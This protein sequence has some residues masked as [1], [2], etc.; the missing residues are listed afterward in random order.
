MTYEE[1][2]K[3]LLNHL[4]R[5]C[6][7]GITP[8]LTHQL[9][10]NGVKKTGITFRFPDTISSPII[11]LEDSFELYQHNGD[12]DEIADHILRLYRTIPKLDISEHFLADFSNIKGTITMKLINTEKNLTL[13]DTVPHI[14]FEDLS[15]VFYCI[16]EITDN[17]TGTVLIDNEKAALWD[18]DTRALHQYALKNY[19]DL[20]SA[21]FMTMS[22]QI[23]AIFSS[24][25]ENLALEGKS[26][27]EMP[28]DGFDD[29]MYVLSN[30]YKHWGAALMTCKSLM[31]DI[32]D[33]FRE[34]F[35]ILPSSIHEVILVPDSKSLFKDEL[36]ALIQEINQTQVPPEEYLSDHAY[37]YSKKGKNTIPCF[38]Q[39]LFLN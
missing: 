20:L 8:E 36:D 11:Y 22:Q 26:V 23:E 19:T 12:L 21:S 39:G 3:E 9:K 33:F 37:H 6:G 7:E 25:D 30:K 15:L 28:V 31:D 13:L 4:Q 27:F 24:Y 2:Q 34:D 17:G 32:A 16:L 1:F 35:Y 14:P 38:G 18:V 5:K 10:G 29:C